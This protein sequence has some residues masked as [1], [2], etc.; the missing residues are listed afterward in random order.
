MKENAYSFGILKIN[1]EMKISKFIDYF[2]KRV[3]ATLL[4]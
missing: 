4:H 2:T 1:C 3:K